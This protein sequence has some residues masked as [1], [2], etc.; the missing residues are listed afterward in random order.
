MQGFLQQWFQLSTIFWTVAIAYMLF[1]TVLRQQTTKDEFR[2]S[3]LLCWGVPLVLACLPFSTDSYGDA[4]AW[5]WIKT[6]G[7]W[8]YQC[9][10]R[11]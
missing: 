6:T 3:L 5:C 2:Y 8:L 7:T 9:F 4:G 1:K 10:I 11:V